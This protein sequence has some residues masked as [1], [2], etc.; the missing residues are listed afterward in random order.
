MTEY[1]IIKSDKTKGESGNYQL[2][3]KYDEQFNAW[4]CC[5]I[6]HTQEEALKD[7]RNFIVEDKNLG[8][9]YP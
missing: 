1:K 6:Y 8:L 7:M 9:L 4:R 3:E 2:L 5:G